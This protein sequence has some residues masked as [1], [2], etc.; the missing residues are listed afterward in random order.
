MLIT[1]AYGHR[2][3]VDGRFEVAFVFFFRIGLHAA[4]AHI[5][6]ER[7][8]IRGRSFDVDAAV[9]FMKIDTLDSI[10]RPRAR[11]SIVVSFAGDTCGR[12]NR[13]GE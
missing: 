11:D 1:A 6:V 4:L 10:R 13:Y 7:D 8:L 3:A 2:V 5:G 9:D 12:E